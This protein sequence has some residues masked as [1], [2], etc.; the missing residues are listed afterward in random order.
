MGILYKHEHIAC[1][2]FLIPAQRSFQV[3]RLLPGNKCTESNNSRSILLF[4]LDGELE[5]SN[6]SVHNYR[7]QKN[8]IALIPAGS[9]YSIEVKKASHL[10]T[11]WFSNDI[12]LCNRIHLESLSQY[13]KEI[14]YKYNTLAFQGKIKNF[15]LLLNHYLEDGIGCKHLQDSKLQELFMLFRAYYTK[16][17]LAAF[18]HPVLSRDTDF[19]HFVLSNYRSVANVEEFARLAHMSLS[20]FNRKFKRYFHEPAYQW[21]MRRKTEGVLE[22]I[23]NTNKSF[24]EISL[25]WNFSSQ[26]HL[27]KFTKKQCGLSPSQIRKQ[28]THNFIADFDQ[29]GT[30]LQLP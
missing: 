2:K 10:I 17:Q 22:D 30:S 4:V 21:M 27:S 6:E 29:N 28:A 8:N 15:L 13:K 16:E 19:N 24:L 26:A 3:F 14:A 18:F 1:N 7:L 25:D 23:R 20:A 11:C 9:H 5:F 12:K